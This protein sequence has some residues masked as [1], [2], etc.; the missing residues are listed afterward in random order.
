MPGGVWVGGSCGPSGLGGA[1]KLL[2]VSSIPLLHDDADV[3]PRLR[4]TGMER[5]HCSE[6]RGQ[7]GPA[8]L[9]PSPLYL[10]PQL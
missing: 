2:S 1:I 10:S 6:V 4:T 9:H 7:D 5:M 8:S 3:Q